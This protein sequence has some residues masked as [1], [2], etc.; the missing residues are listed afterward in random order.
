MQ[1][2]QGG[3]R[4]SGSHRHK[5]ADSSVIHVKGGGYLAGKRHPAGRTNIAE[6]TQMIAIEGLQLLPSLPDCSGRS[7]SLSK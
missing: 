4:E 2:R 1:A 3:G 5:E 7:L 6:I